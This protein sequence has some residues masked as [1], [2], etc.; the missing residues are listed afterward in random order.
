MNAAPKVVMVGASLD[1]QG[2]VAAVLGVYRDRGF[3]ERWGVEYVPTNCP[4]SAWR[5]AVC[6]LAAGLRFAGLLLRGG[7][8]VV[9]VHTSSYSSFWRKSF[10]FAMAF[11][12]HRI[13]VV[14]LH[15]GGFREFYADTC[16]PVGRWWVRTVIGKTARFIVLTDG[17]KQW[18]LSVVPEAEVR[19]IPNL[20]PNPACTS[21]VK[22]ENDTASSVLFL[23]RL[24]KEKGFH[25]LLLAVARIRDRVPGFRLVCGGTGN[26]SEVKRWIE[27][28]GV[29]DLVEL[30]GWV[31]GVAKQACFERAAMLV[32]PSYIENFPMVIIEAMAAGL[33]VVATAVGGVPDVIEH[34]KEGLLVQPGDVGRLADAIASLLLDREL[35]GRMARAA[36]HKYENRYSPGCVVPQLESVYR[37]LGVA[38]QFA[39]AKSSRA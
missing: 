23:G 38:P 35:R 22:A 30:R 14:S 7:G 24:E 16:G 26:A 1:S 34:G 39:G 2:G 13:V 10:F 20:S 29:G 4:G 33:P 5:K 12:F 27:S 32:L 11:L 15:G 25:D 17:W 19:T 6:A 31:S 28:A 21:V 8:Q 18:V 3:F 9:H 36:R 37:E